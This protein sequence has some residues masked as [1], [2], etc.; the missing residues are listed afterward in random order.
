MFTSDSYE[1]VNCILLDFSVITFFG[2][3]CDRPPVILVMEYCP[4]DSLENHLL[5]DRGDTVVERALYCYEAARGMR[6]LH[7]QVCFYIYIF[8]DSEVIILDKIL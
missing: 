5:A 6:Y 4:G 7:V 2:V 3:A 1:F 8:T